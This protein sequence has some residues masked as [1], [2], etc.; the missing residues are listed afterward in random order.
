MEAVPVDRLVKGDAGALHDRPIVPV[1]SVELLKIDRPAVVLGS[2]QSLDAVR[3]DRA[4]E[5]GFAVVRRRSGGGVVILQPGDHVWIDVTVP[6]GHQLWSDDVVRATWW[7]GDAWCEVL[8]V[9]DDSA[10]WAVHRDKLQASAPE[11]A[12]C[13]ASV[14]PGEVV[15]RGGGSGAADRGG[16]VGRGRG[17]GRKVVGISQRRTKD[18][19]RFQCTVFSAVD[20][21][22][23]ERLMRD[24]VP[25]SLA[26]ATGVGAALASL[27]PLALER[28]TAALR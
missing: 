12:V 11:R 22:L 27:A 23:H 6:R 8:R 19:A 13:F 24:P 26:D 2:T 18:A 14:G 16:G 25:P 5:L 21:A 28:F 9:V 4:A 17:A 10:E 15:R 3:G 20:V 1:A 7:L